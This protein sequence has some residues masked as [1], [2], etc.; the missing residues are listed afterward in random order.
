MEP[1]ARLRVPELDP[2]QSPS[3]S[4][5]HWYSSLDRC[6]TQNLLAPLCLVTS[7]EAGLMLCYGC[8]K[9]DL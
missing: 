5:G 9:H 3:P 2:I 7:W 6:S 8:C 1:Q 4:H